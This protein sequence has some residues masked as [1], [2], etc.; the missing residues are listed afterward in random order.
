MAYSKK[1][2]VTYG[3]ASS[4][5]SCG[6][7]FVCFATLLSSTTSTSQKYVSDNCLLRTTDPLCKSCDAATACCQTLSA[8]S[9]STSEM[10]AKKDLCKYPKV[11]ALT[12]ALSICS[13]TIFVN[14]SPKAPEPES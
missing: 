7:S 6:I 9:A 5:K 1:L 12:L 14:V 3:L 8:S 4:K 11:S 13:E 2:F 10:S